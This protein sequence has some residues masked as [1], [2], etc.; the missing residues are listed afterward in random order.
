MTLGLIHASFLQLY[1]HYQG[2]AQ[3]RYAWL[4]RVYVSKVRRVTP[5]VN[6]I[7]LLADTKGNKLKEFHECFL[8]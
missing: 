3:R 7:V 4:I 2:I 5:L 6:P 8:D 1:N